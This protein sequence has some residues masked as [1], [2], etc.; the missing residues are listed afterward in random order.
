[1]ATFV[2]W[3]VVNREPIS[4]VW[5]QLAPISPQICGF[6][7]TWLIAN[8]WLWWCC[9]ILF[10]S[11]LISLLS[12]Y[13]GHEIHIEN[14]TLVDIWRCSWCHCLRKLFYKNW[15]FLNCNV[16]SLQEQNCSFKMKSKSILNSWKFFHDWL[17]TKKHVNIV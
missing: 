1:M 3:I 16:K 11:P 7:V 13:F 5:L 8:S 9:D 15:M 17:S 4:L 12:L 10:F 6:W 2:A 14:T